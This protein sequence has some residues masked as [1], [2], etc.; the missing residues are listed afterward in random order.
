MNRDHKFKVGEKYR[1]KY[2]HADPSLKLVKLDNQ[3]VTIKRVGSHYEEQYY[4]EIEEIDDD[5]N[6]GPHELEPI[7]YEWDS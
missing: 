3:I 7:N 1:Y 2:C 6:V 5:D 4:L